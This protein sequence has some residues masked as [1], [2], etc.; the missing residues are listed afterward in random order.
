MAHVDRLVP[1]E[2]PLYAVFPPDPGVRF[3]APRALQPLRPRRL[4]AGG[5]LLLWEDEWRRLR[6]ANGRPLEVLAVS[7]ARQSRRGQLSVAVAPRGPLA[8][9]RDPD[10]KGGA[11]VPPTGPSAGSELRA[12]PGD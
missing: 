10:G 8:W 3:Y 7:A 6:D 9:K 5:Y 2:E 1:A 11:A 4:D 12:A